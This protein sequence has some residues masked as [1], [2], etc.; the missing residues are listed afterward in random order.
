[1]SPACASVKGPVHT[2]TAPPNTEAAATRLATATRWSTDR[3]P[4]ASVSRRRGFCSSQSART[5]ARY[6]SAPRPGRR[7]VAPKLRARNRSVRG[8]AASG[9]APSLINPGQKWLWFAPLRNDRSSVLAPKG[10]QFDNLVMFEGPVERGLSSSLGQSPVRQATL[11]RRRSVGQR[12]ILRARIVPTCGIRA[13]ASSRPSITRQS[14][15]EPSTHACT[16]ASSR[17]SRT[18]RSLSTEL[19]EVDEL[20]R[21]RGLC[22]R[23]MPPQHGRL[24]GAWLAQKHEAALDDQGLGRNGVR[25][26]AQR[27]PQGRRRVGEKAVTVHLVRP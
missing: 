27:P 20:G 4:A 11:S 21:A 7:P 8:R 10:Q 2:A 25:I 23:L 24:P 17:T 14:S 3:S 1:M 16:L 13:L 12:S 22:E 9:P 18:N 6:S 5:P 19:R 15:P 26:A